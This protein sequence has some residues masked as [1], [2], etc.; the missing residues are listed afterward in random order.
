MGRRVSRCV[1]SSGRASL[2][3][4]LAMA[5]GSALA[6]AQAQVQ[7]NP[8]INWNGWQI[9]P[10]GTIGA[11][12]DDN[13]NP[14]GGSRIGGLGTNLG[15]SLLGNRVS[16]LHSTTIYAT[17]A[18][19]LFPDHWDFNTYS[20]NG[21]IGHRYEIMPDLVLNADANASW[22]TN[23]LSTQLTPGSVGQQ[24]FAQEAGT[25]RLR[26]DFINVYVEGRV[27]ITAQQITSGSQ[28]VAADSGANGYAVTGAVRM[29]YK[30]GPDLSIFVEPSGNWQRFDSSANNQNGYQIIAGIAADKLSLFSGE[31][32]G[33][34]ARQDYSGINRD[35]PVTPTYGGSISWFPT[36]ELTFRVGYDESWG[37]GGLNQNPAFS[38]LG[39][40]QATSNPTDP[41][42]PTP[43]APVLPGN[44]NAISLPNDYLSYYSGLGRTRT[45]SLNANYVTTSRWSAAGNLSYQSQD[46]STG[47]SSGSI[48]TAGAVL[49]YRLPQSWGVALSYTYNRVDNDQPGTVSYNRNVVALGLTA[50]F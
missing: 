19:Q 16:G 30:I 10:S 20:V 4:G 39:V 21:G 45:V 6:P 3:L 48:F 17:G 1:V 27:G 23:S 47:G 46:L 28:F 2:A 31:L 49:S 12:Y 44:I 33:G 42:N 22:Y 7:E 50:K 43:G 5:V 9:S 37:L 36:R 24:D 41:L 11:V 15:A 26:K 38:Q 29:G 32:H 8:P 25:L 35:D 13:L 18:A 40:V 14:S 34:I